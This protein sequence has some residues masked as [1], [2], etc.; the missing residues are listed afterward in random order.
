[1]TS[2]LLTKDELAQ[3]T[4]TK[5]PKRMARWLHAR[6]WVYEPAARRGDVPK[7]DRGY[8]QARMAGA[9][10]GTVRRNGPRLDWMLKRT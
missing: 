5:Q 6:Q 10:P 7:V 3:L 4:G 8:C 1:M 2:L 9:A